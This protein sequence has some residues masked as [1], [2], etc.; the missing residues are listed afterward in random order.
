VFSGIVMLFKPLIVMMSLGLLGYTKRSS[1]KTAVSLSQVS[2]FSLVF[3]VAA[4]ASGRVSEKVQAVISLVA[5]ITFALSA[6]LMKYDDTLYGKLERYLRLFERRVLD[7]ERP[8]GVHGYPI[9]IFGYR[10]GGQEFIRTFK[11]MNKR[12]VVVDYD[13]EAIELLEAQKVNVLYGDATDPELIEELQL[14]RSKLVVSTISDYKTNEFLA[15]WLH[16]NNPQAV[17]ISSAETASQASELYGL[18]AAYVMMPHFIGSEK[19]STFIKRIGF[20]KSEFHKFRNK[21]LQYLETH[22]SQEP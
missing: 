1:F 9:V 13:P 2:E 8:G 20:K 4:V 19:I 22:Y 18:G 11:S 10:K 7:Y 6:Y 17:L 16:V 21:H 3:V 15:H 12:F 14:D 5:L